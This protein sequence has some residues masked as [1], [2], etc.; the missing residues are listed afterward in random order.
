MKGKIVR[1][2]D[3]WT[4]IQC[5]KCKNCF[6]LLTGKYHWQ[7]SCPYCSELLEIGKPQ[8]AAVSAEE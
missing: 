5:P 6:K 8:M 2:E 1:I 7:M 3:Q 4:V